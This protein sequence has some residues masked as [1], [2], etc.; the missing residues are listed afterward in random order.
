MPS[1]QRVLQVGDQLQRLLA[2]TLLREIKDPRLSQ[3]NITAVKLSRDLS[4]AKVYFTCGNKSQEAA[5]K[6]FEKA[7]AFFKRAISKQCQLRIVPNLQ[8]HYD[9]SLA[10]GEHLTSLIN[11][12]M[13]Q[14]VSDPDESTD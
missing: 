12:A 2:E 11:K 14:V 6:A 1:S 4:H 10:R 13:D 9:Q 7:K 5:L 8:F 3:V